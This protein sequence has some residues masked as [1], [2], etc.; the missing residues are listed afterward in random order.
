MTA[1]ANSYIAQERAYLLEMINSHDTFDRNNSEDM[2]AYTLCYSQYSEYVQSQW[3][4][5]DSLMN[6]Y[7]EKRP[8]TRAVLAT[9]GPS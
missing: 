4:V 1:Q 3:V 8:V 6:L 5:R 9:M 2:A 7:P